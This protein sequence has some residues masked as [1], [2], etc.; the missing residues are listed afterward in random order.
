VE[1]YRDAQR[2][3]LRREASVEWELG[4]RHELRLL[5]DDEAPPVGHGVRRAEGVLRRRDDLL[6]DAPRL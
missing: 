5:G 1:N 2:D 4:A 6:S 3:L